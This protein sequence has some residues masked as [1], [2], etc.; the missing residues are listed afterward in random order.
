MPVTIKQQKT[1]RD[2]FRQKPISTGTGQFPKVNE[3]TC[4][5]SNKLISIFFFVDYHG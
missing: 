4:F 2:E 5:F 1:C 3:L